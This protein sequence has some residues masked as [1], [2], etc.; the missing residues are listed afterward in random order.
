ML[1]DIEFFWE[2][3]KQPEQMQMPDLLIKE[4]QAYKEKDVTEYLEKELSQGIY[5][6]SQSEVLEDGKYYIALVPQ[7]SDYKRS[8]VVSDLPKDKFVFRIALNYDKEAY[9][10][11]GNSKY[12]TV[13]SIE[14]GQMKGEKDKL[15]SPEDALEILESPR[16]LTYK[17]LSNIY[18]AI[19]LKNFNYFNKQ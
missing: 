6:L 12:G 1:N 10:E 9:D 3:K 7:E 16:C 14:F 8:P 11:K 2:N 5:T 19:I 4:L 18:S 17:Q 13:E 15:Y